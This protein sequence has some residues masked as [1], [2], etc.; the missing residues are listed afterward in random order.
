MS[1]QHGGLSFRR[2]VRVVSPA[3]QSHPCPS[4]GTSSGGLLPA[5]PGISPW[6]A[7]A[8]RG[9]RTARPLPVPDSL[10]WVLPPW[11]LPP[12][13]RLPFPAPRPVLSALASR[14]ARSPAPGGLSLSGRVSGPDP[15]LPATPI[16]EIRLQ[17]VRPGSPSVWPHSLIPA[18]LGVCLPIGR[19]LA[20]AITAWV[21]PG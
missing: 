20:S 5:A 11:A 9:V 10:P 19:H 2:W 4:R 12:Q 14:R 16:R 21:Q 18:R 13:A 6:G 8:G 1:A 3:Q 7:A 17:H 15:S